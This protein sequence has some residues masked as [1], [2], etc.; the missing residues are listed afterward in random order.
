MWL[1]G[2]ERS[3]LNN[4]QFKQTLTL[5]FKINPENYFIFV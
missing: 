4:N 3:I 5:F 1:F 2:G